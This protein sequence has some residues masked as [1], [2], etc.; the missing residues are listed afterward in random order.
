MVIFIRFPPLGRPGAPPD[1]TK[2]Q[3][4]SIGS[5]DETLKASIAAFAGRIHVAPLSG[6][7]DDGLM[8]GERPAAMGAGAAAATRWHA[9]GT[10]SDDAVTDHVRRDRPRS[11][12]QTARSVEP[13]AGGLCAIDELGPT[14]R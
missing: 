12:R 2:K 8:V 5:H 11:Q 10:G 9:R 14:A 1:T 3:L 6:A 13:S 4:S 7:T